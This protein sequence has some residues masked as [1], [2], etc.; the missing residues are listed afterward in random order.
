[1]YLEE[2]DI[3]RNT[4]R[5]GDIVSSV[6]LLGAININSIN[7]SSTAGNP[8]DKTS[9]MMPAPPKYGDAMVL[10]HSCEVALENTVKVTSIILAPLRDINTATD[11]FRIAELISSNLIDQSNPNASFLKYFYV[12]P[13]HRCEYQNGAIVDFSKCFSIR[14]KSYD[15]LVQ[16]KIAQLNVDSI[17]SMSLKL[18]LYFHR[19]GN[20]VA[21]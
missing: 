20:L 2:D 16:N 5:Q 17:Q 18:A 14:N 8:D 3:E 6:H 1:M 4:L 9:W 19:T 21:A 11:K 15:L 13:N 10:S 12:P 7:Y